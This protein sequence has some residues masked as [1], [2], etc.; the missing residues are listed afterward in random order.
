MLTCDGVISVN[1]LGPSSVGSGGSGGSLL[2]K[3]DMLRGH[4]QLT[5]NGGSASTGEYC[6]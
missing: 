4:G 6:F 5:A 3:T 2:V 1:G